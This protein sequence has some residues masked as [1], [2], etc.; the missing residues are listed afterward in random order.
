MATRQ[1]YYIESVTA[2]RDKVDVN[3]YECKRNIMTMIATTFYYPSSTMGS[4]TEVM[5]RLH[6]LG[7]LTTSEVRKQCTVFKTNSEMKFVNA[8]VKNT[9]YKRYRKDKDKNYISN[10]FQINKLTTPVQ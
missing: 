5:H 10:I 4:D 2:K 1:F 3:I 6:E 7:I 9:Y 8:K